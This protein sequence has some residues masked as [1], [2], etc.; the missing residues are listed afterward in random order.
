[1]K[2]KLQ[3]CFRCA[4]IKLAGM[5]YFIDM[6]L[7]SGERDW[8]GGGGGGGERRRREINDTP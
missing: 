3:S 6:V 4:A 2:T 7:T 8:E 1:M 5:R